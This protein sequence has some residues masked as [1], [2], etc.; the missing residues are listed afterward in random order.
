MAHALALDVEHSHGL[1]ARDDAHE[2]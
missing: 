2:P 1:L